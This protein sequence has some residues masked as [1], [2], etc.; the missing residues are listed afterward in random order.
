MVGLFD[1]FWQGAMVGGNDRDAAVDDAVVG[2]CCGA[3]VISRPLP[4][5]RHIAPA[6]NREIHGA[7]A[8]HNVSLFIVR[9]GVR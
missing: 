2:C 6:R 9:R 3:T 4:S 5:W 1:R 8:E 7:H